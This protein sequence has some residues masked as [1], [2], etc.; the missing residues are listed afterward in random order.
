MKTILEIRSISNALKNADE[1][2]ISTEVVWSALHYMK[3]NPQATLCDAI[4][5]GLLEWVK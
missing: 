3:E 2:G 4:S 1:Y 5:Y